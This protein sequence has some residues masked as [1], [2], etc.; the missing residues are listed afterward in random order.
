MLCV[1]LSSDGSHF[2]AELSFVATTPPIDRSC[3]ELSLVG[4]LSHFIEWDHKNVCLRHSN[5]VEMISLLV[6]LHLTSQDT[7]GLVMCCG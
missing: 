1:I 7:V 2:T 6:G 4:H 3:R 5:D